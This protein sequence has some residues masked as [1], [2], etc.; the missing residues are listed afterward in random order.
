VAGPPLQMH[1][2]AKVAH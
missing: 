2:K 1:V